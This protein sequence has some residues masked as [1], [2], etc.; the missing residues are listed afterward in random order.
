MRPFFDAGLAAGVERNDLDFPL[1]G[2][3]SRAVVG[4][5]L[6]FGAAISVSEHWYVRPLGRIVG[7]STTE[8]GGFA[9]ASAGYRF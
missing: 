4:G 6:G 1:G 2:R 3:A 8:V 9:G 7:L 5:M